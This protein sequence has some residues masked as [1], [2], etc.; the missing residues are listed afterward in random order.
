MTDFNIHDYKKSSIGDV[1]I[2]EVADP[3]YVNTTGDIM[4]GNLTLPNVVLYGFNSGITFSDGSYLHTKPVEFK[5][6]DILNYDNVFTK[7]NTFNDTLQANKTICIKDTYGNAKQSTIIQ[8][9]NDLRINTPYGKLLLGNI[10]ADA[11]EIGNK[12]L[13]DVITD[14]TNP[15]HEQIDVLNE[16]SNQNTTSILNNTTNIS[17]LQSSYVIQQNQINQNTIDISNK[18]N[19]ISSNNLLSSDLIEL[20]DASILSNKLVEMT[21]DINT[22]QNIINENNKLPISLVDTSGSLLYNVEEQ[23]TN[24]N[25]SI[26]TLQG[27]DGSATTSFT[28][29]NNAISNLQNSKQNAITTNSLLSSNLIELPD[30]SIL[31][32]KI[33][34]LED[35][36]GTLQGF[37][38]GA[39]TGFN[40]INNNIT[41]INNSIS[42]IQTDITDLENQDLIL[43]NNINLKQNLINSNNKLPITSIDLSTSPLRFIDISSNLQS[44]LTGFTNS[45]NTLNSKTTNLSNSNALTTLNNDLLAGG[46][47]LVKP[48][49]S[50]SLTSYV[51]NNINSYL[52]IGSFTI[53]S[54]ANINNTMNFH[55][56]RILTSNNFFYTFEASAFIQIKKQSDNSIVHTSGNISP[57]TPGTTININASVEL[58]PIDYNF[59]LTSTSTPIIYDVYVASSFAS[60]PQLTTQVP[61]ANA[62]ISYNLNSPSLSY[63]NY[64]IIKTGQTNASTTGSIAFTD[65]L[66]SN[67]VDSNTMNCNLIT[68]TTLSTYNMVATASNTAQLIIGVQSYNSGSNIT[69]DTRNFVFLYRDGGTNAITV[70]IPDGLPVGM[71]YEIRKWRS[72]ATNINF[73]ANNK[74]T[75]ADNYY[76]NGGTTIT[77]STTQEYFKLI[78]YDLAGDGNRLWYIVAYT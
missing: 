45:I 57:Y 74:I 51:Y 24:I 42:T 46:S 30:T 64:T 49:L 41:S 2:Q 39:I 14:I 28:N 52:K 56:T 65:N 32:S 75:Q 3:I 37:D 58:T 21:N 11:I 68:S 17:Q 50:V 47:M 27:F 66:K 48:S 72:T 69:L 33:N 20:N 34:D 62:E 6:S 70:N 10:K 77:M 53:S 35:A 8:T 67:S 36:I 76:Y 29:I 61:S 22:K 54:S 7:T 13:N 12:T 19:T 38:N 16:N 55:I 78:L 25:N 44:Q 63:I 18:Q 1:D 5:R 40:S 71:F 26:S 73:P 60:N 31:T 4:S 9:N 15:M 43:Q 23:L 59:T